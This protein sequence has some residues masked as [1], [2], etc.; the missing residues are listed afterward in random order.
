M[1]PVLTAYQIMPYLCPNP[2]ALTRILPF[3]TFQAQKAQGTYCTA[4]VMESLVVE[5]L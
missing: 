4:I 5:I 1:S 2:S 3:A